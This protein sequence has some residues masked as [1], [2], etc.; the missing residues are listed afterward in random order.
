[1]SR[2]P[3]ENWEARTIDSRSPKFRIDVALIQKWV[4]RVL[5]SIKFMRSQ[6][7]KM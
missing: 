2:R 1:M 3:N 6:I 4:P 5:M 7:I